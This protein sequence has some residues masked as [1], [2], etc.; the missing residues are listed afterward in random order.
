MKGRDKIYKLGNTLTGEPTESY[1]ATNKLYEEAEKIENLK[2]LVNESIQEII[3]N[4]NI[5]RNEIIKLREELNKFKNKSG[6]KPKLNYEEI[7]KQRDS[8]K[9][10]RKIAEIYEV[11]EGAIRHCLKRGGSQDGK[12][13]NNRYN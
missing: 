2:L 12:T 3:R 8:G 13:S 7:Q 11:S 1:K 6:K 10:Y 9:S 5:F 4:H